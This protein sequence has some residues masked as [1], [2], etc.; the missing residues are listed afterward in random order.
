MKKSVLIIAVIL[1]S[2]TATRSFAQ[3]G[4]AAPPAAAKDT[5]VMDISATMANTADHSTFYAAIKAANLESFLKGAGP[6][7]V[8]APDN[9]AFNAV[10]KGRLDSLM[11]DTAKLA[12]AIK[13]HILAGKYDK[14]ALIKALTDGKGKATLKTV[15]GQTLMLGVNNKKL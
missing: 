6:Y 11:K 8:F 12:V 4:Q 9:D 2:L 13:A 14:A 15:D 1:I 3:M 7:T 10:P 5:S